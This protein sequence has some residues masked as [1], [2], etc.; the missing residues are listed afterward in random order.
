MG[1]ILYRQ[2]SSRQFDAILVAEERRK[3]FTLEIFVFRPPVDIE[4]SG[5][6]GIWAPFEHI[7]P[8]RIVGAADSHVVR[9]KIQNLSKSLSSKDRDHLGKVF[10]RAQLGV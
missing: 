8:E 3:Y 4:P 6:G 7:E 10:F 5:I 2:L 9:H 1:L